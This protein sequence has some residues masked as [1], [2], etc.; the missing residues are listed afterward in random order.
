MESNNC[1]SWLYGLGIMVAIAI[2]MLFFSG[3]FGN[4]SL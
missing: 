1:R 3:Q 2:A 4:W